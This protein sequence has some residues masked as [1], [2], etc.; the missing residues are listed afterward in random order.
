MD[1][2]LLAG[3]LALCIVCCLY[4]IAQKTIDLAWRQALYDEMIAWK[5]PRGILYI[6]NEGSSKLLRKRNGFLKEP[7]MLVPCLL[8]FA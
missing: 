4:A 2:W 1:E 7:L 8:I 3:M 5:D 6:L